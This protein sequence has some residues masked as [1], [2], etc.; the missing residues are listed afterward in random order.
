[1]ATFAD[2]QNTPPVDHPGGTPGSESTPQ[3][4]T[5]QL[6]SQEE[7]AAI[8]KR[9]KHAQEHIQRLERERA[10]D[11]RRMEEIQA[12]LAR[13]R[14]EVEKAKSLEELLARG[15]RQREDE[16]TETAVDPDKLVS[17]VLSRIEAQKAEAQRQ[18]NIQAALAKARE[19]YGEGWKDEVKATAKELGLTMADVDDIAARSLAAFERTFIRTSTQPRKPTGNPLNSDAVRGASQEVDLRALYRENPK[20]LFSREAFEQIAQSLKK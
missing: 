10:E 17:T 12:E 1:M 18:A 16:D 11:R 6:P 2:D 14:A 9:D 20:K 15:G 7:L 8:L 5:A 13:Y 19:V 4:G 3:E